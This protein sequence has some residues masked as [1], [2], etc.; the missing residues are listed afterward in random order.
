MSEFFLT[1]VNMSISA[2]WIVL[3]VLLLRLLLKKAP[4]WITVLLWGIVAVRLICSFTIESVMSLIPSAETIS[5]EIMMDATPEINSGIPILNNTINPVISESFAPDP[6][7]SANP[8]QILIPVLSVVWVVGTAVMLVYTAIS[9]FK[10]KRKIGTAV[11][12]RDNIFQSES[13]ISPFVLGLIKPKIYLPFGMNEQ[14]MSHV[15]AHEQAHIRRKDHWWK[16]FGFLILTLHW[17]NPLMW[18]GYILLCRDIELACDEKI[19]KELNTEQ[20]ADYSQALLTCSVNRRMIAACPLAFGEVGVKDRVRSVLNYKKPAFWIIVV[21]IITSVAV[22]VCFLTNPT[23]DKLKN[24]ENR[25]LNS[26]SEETVAVWVSDGETYHSIS[27]INVDLLEELSNIKISR[28]E[29][30]LNRSE[31][32]DASHTLVL[33]TKQD[34]EPTIYSYLKGLYIHFNSD[35]SSVWVNDGVKPTLSYRVIN[36][37]KAKQI[38]EDIANFAGDEKLIWTYQP[39]LSFTGHSFRGFSFDFDY[40]HIEA[41]CT[42]GEFC[43]LD[44]AGQPYGTKMRFENEN[45]V[46]WTPKE[47]VIEKIPQQSEVTLEIYNNETQVHKCTIVFECVSRDTAKAE[48]EIYLKVPDGLQMVSTDVDIK[49][50]EQSSISNVGST[51]SSNVQTFESTVSYANWAEASEIYF[52]SLNKDKMAISSIKHLPIYRFDTLNDLEQFKQTFGG[53]FTMDGSWDEVPSFNNATAKYD[54]AF[55]EDNSLILVYVSANN[56]THR[57]KVHSIGY[58]EKSFCVHIA[59]TTNAEAVDTAMAGWFVTVAVSDELI[60]NCTEFDADLNN[61]IELLNETH[62]QDQTAIHYPNH[63][64]LYEVTPVHDIQ[65]KYDNEE[66]VYQKLHYKVADG[67]WSCEGYTYKYRLEITGRLNNAAK[68][69]TYIVLS[70]SKDITFDQTWK[71]S[72]LSSLMSDYFEPKDAVIVGYKLFS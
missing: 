67:T 49:L 14:D 41:T 65:A 50:V 24:I 9:Y 32:R 71:A 44:V 64:E 27:T 61:G 17:F 31:D 72:G 56:S 55:F 33:Q 22:A 59:E 15:I 16:P 30:S 68:S 8:L 18:L 13:V 43:N 21:A 42:G 60:K 47:A 53:I 19:I 3:A 46:Y 38:Y 34:T 25:T 69:T 35:F 40:T 52:G 20:K 66:F 5:P 28:K 29:V 26:I 12:L 57:F 58:D 23:S 70:N 48:F 62:S 2:S 10:V 4:K 39:M 1:I 54:S 45:T 6:V 51:D 7:T 36:P 11:L 37:Q 63:L